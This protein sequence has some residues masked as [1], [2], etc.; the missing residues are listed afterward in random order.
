MRSHLRN[1]LAGELA[2]D[3]APIHTCPHCGAMH[4]CTTAL[5]RDREVTVG[6][7]LLCADCG[8]A[9]H[10]VSEDLA[11]EPFDLATIE[12]PEE[13][14]KIEG[15]SALIRQKVLA[16]R[17]PKSSRLE[18]GYLHACQR[19]DRILVAQ[20]A[21]GGEPP[22]F[23]LPPME[24]GLIASLD[25]PTL[26]LARNDAARVF[27][28]RACACAPEDMATVYMLEAVLEHRGLA[29][30]RVSLTE[31]GILRDAPS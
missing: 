21:K 31:L 6:A 23:A 10:V 19:L 30:E 27:L 25:H 26:E 9:A 12:D 16:T 24:I 29:I 22:R 28:V 7:I 14:K 20:L 5:Q 2:E 18:L 8:G 3:R 4:D 1:K 11:L 15:A 17:S 13:R